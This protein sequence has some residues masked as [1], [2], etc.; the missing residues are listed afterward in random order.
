VRIDAFDYDLPAE[1]VAQRPAERREDARLLYLPRLP[2]GGLEH[3]RVAALP[4]LLPPG[5]LVVVND[6]RVIPAR[7]LGQRSSG[8]RVEI[9]LVRKD[10]ARADVWQALG[11]ANKS[12]KVGAEVEVPTRESGDGAPGLV[13]RVL[14]RAEDGSLEVALR[15]PSGGSVDDAIRA[16]GHVPLPPYIKRADAADDTDRYQTVYARNDGAVAAPTAGLHLTEDLL[17]RM[18][19]RDCE[20]ATVTLHVGLGTFLPVE[21]EDLDA[22]PMHSERVVVPRATCEAVDRARSRGAPVVAIGTTTVR[23]L[24]TAADP[25]RPGHVVPFDGETRLLIQ[26]G[27]AWRVVDGLLTNFHLP[28]STLLAL[29]CAF[30]GTDRV[31]GAYRTAVAEGYRFF[32]YGDAMLLWRAG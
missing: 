28:R 24:E 5:A 16:C 26:P 10:E 30:G 3:D 18:R 31:L 19:R 15:C 6:T 11:R 29:V 13:V 32:S 7:L 2:A 23:S 4:E 21:V 22:H 8:G 20:I 25:D 9:F 14:G 17:G 27:Y 1:R 12:L